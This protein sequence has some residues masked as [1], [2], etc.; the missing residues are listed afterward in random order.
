MVP[1]LDVY[2]V[3][4]GMNARFW[5]CFSEEDSIGMLKK[6]SATVSNRHVEKFLPKIS[7]LRQLVGLHFF[8]QI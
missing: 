4:P 3:G 1:G 8:D 5:H 7:R 2:L 6:V